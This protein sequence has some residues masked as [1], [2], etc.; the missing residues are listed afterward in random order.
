MKTA[1]YE[2]CQWSPTSIGSLASTPTTSVASFR[3]FSFASVTANFAFVFGIHFSS[4][5]HYKSPQTHHPVSNNTFPSPNRPLLVSLYFIYRVQGCS[6]HHIRITSFIK[7]SNKFALQTMEL[8]ITHSQL[9]VICHR[10]LKTF[11]SMSK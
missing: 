1:I 10:C 4:F 6:L 2:Y 8:E 5:S 11:D 9:T 3:I 7:K